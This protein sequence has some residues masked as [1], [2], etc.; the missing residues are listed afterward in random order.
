MLNLAKYNDEEMLGRVNFYLY[1]PENKI[2]PIQLAY[3]FYIERRDHEYYIKVKTSTN[4][5]IKD[6][7]Y[8]IEKNNLLD[9]AKSIREKNI[10]KVDLNRVISKNSMSN[11][12]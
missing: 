3:D 6:T 7:S 12:R 10:Y 9:V 2:K 11:K 8:L 1:D 5:M 4:T